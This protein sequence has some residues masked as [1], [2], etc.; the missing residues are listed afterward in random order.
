MFMLFVT[1]SNLPRRHLWT[2]R[3][4]SVHGTLHPKKR[5][6]SVRERPGPRSPRGPET[7]LRACG[8]TCFHSDASNVYEPCARVIQR[9]ARKSQPEGC[10]FSCSKPE[11]G[12]AQRD[13]EI[14]SKQ[15]RKCSILLG[16]AFSRDHQIL[17]RAKK[18]RKYYLRTPAPS[19]PGQQALAKWL[20][21]EAPSRAP[22][23]WMSRD[24]SHLLQGVQET[25]GAS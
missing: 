7:N 10:C 19:H 25:L 1:H 23:R 4:G 9:R 14:G 17:S 24:L 20:S 15:T 5:R 2:Y 16:R 13:S 18:D 6:R 8:D 21:R 22:R 12:G 3:M 11:R